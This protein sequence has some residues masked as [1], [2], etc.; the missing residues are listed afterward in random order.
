M[1]Y[2]SIKT[3]ETGL[4]I[5]REAART[6]RGLIDGSI[7]PETIPATAQWVR[8]C[9]NR[10]DDDELIMHAI[11]AVLENF[12]VEGLGADLGRFYRFAPQYCYSNTGDS[13]APTVI[14]NNET[15][16][17]SVGSWADLVESGKVNEQY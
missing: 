17:Y 1:N 7:N 9:F 3:I 14:L 13:Y 4:D 6:I 5:D 10:P 2:P 15:G 16:R 12:G 11:D 8:E